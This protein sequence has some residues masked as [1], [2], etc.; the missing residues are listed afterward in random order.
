M[1]VEGA[2]LYTQKLNM[3]KNLKASNELTADMFENIKYK[4]RQE[5]QEAEQTIY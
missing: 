3:I 4:Q 5:L 2:T 1:F